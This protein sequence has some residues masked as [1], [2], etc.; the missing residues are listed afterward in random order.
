[1]GT[2][3]YRI[4]LGVNIR[5][6]AHYTQLLVYDFDGDGRAELMMKTAPGTRIIRY[7]PSGSQQSE[8]FIT[9]PAEDVEAGYGH[10]DDYRMSRGDY[11]EHVVRMF[12]GWHAHEEVKSGRWPARL[13][14]VFGMPETFD[15][16]LSRDS[17]VRIADYFMDVYAPSRSKRNNLRAF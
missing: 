16:P 12:M 2:L 1:D 5:A 7:D 3:L 8:T 15:Y 4:D 17:A 13:E 14:A 11:Y 6:G 9:M 10:T